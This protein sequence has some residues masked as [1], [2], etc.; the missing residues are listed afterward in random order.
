MLIDGDGQYHGLIS[1]G[2]LEGNLLEHARRV[3]GAGSTQIV[4]YDLRGEADELWGLGIG[5]GR[6]VRLLLQPVGLE[7]D[8]EPFACIAAVLRGHH[9]A[10]VMLVIASSHPRLPLGATVA[11]FGNGPANALAE[12]GVRWVRL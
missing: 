9:P 8:F 7:H 3:L 5:C 1:G 10:K 6:L 11:S 4:T 12:T 2:C